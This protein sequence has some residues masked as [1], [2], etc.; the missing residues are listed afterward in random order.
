[1]LGY[2]KPPPDEGAK[3]KGMRNAPRYVIACET[4]AWHLKIWNKAT[5]HIVRT[6]PYKC[7]SWRHEGECRMRKGAQDFVRVKE[8]MEKWD[9]WSH[10]VLTF[11]REPGVSEEDCFLAAGQQWSVMRKRL[12]RAWAPLK[13][14]QTWERHKKGFPHCHLAITSCKLFEASY[15]DPR[16][17]WEDLLMDD[18]VDCGFGYIGWCEQI[19]S[20]QAMAGYLCKL[21]RELTG[22]GAKNQV[23][24]QAPPHFRRLRASQK[25]LPPVDK[26]PDISGVLD[27]TRLP[28]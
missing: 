25:T 19:R 22:V 2:S 12:E 14:I 4:C 1:M 27:F 6:V 5:P 26:N 20:K 17:N 16:S 23:P 18:A 9:F 21:A 7:L 11:A 13:Y 10:C 24:I 3:L 15:R 8:A 28:P